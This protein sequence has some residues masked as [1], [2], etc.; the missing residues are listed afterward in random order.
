MNFLLVNVFAENI[1][2]PIENT[3]SFSGLWQR[4]FE[5][6]PIRIIKWRMFDSE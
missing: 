3:L 5:V 6:T 1:E 2:I 4:L